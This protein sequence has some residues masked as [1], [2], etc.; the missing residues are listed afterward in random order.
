MQVIRNRISLTSRRTIKFG[1]GNIRDVPQGN[2]SRDFSREKYLIKRFFPFIH[3]AHN[4]RKAL[5]QL[6]KLTFM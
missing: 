2:S 3:V 1:H 6:K 5:V 4:K